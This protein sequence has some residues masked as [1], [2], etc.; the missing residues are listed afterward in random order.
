M[1]LSLSIPSLTLSL[2][3]SHTHTHTCNIMS[4]SL[5]FQLLLLVS[6]YIKLLNL[7]KNSIKTVPVTI[8]S[9]E[10][11]GVK[12]VEYCILVD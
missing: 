2:S 8:I 4:L 10:L 9:T 11:T 6:S 5:H 12:K 7:L 1:Q 3:L